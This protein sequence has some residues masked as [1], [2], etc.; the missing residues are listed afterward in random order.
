MNGTQGYWLDDGSL[1]G[2]WRDG[3]IIPWEFDLDMGVML[4]DCERYTALKD[5]MAKDGLTLYKRG[6]YI[7]AKK[8][9]DTAASGAVAEAPTTALNAVELA[10]ERKGAVTSSLRTRHPDV[11]S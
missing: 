9:S 4:E 10:S 8:K 3:G 1:L 5:A 2:A 11:L 6:D 7:A